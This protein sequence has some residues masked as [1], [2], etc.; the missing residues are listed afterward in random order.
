MLVPTLF[1]VSDAEY[2]SRARLDVLRLAFA[3]ELFRRKTGDYPRQLSKLKP[4]YVQTIP[5]DY[6]SDKPLQYVRPGQG[7]AIYSVGRNGKNDLGRS[8]SDAEERDG[9]RWDDV[10]VRVNR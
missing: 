9:A 10:V 6:F 3:A 7:F 8:R 2:E 5:I 1:G 4:D